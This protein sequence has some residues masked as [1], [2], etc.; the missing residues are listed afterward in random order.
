[1]VPSFWPAARYGGP[2][3]SVRRLCACLADLGVRVD[4]A[5]TN[6]DGPGDLDVAIDRWIPL[7]GFRVRYFARWPRFGYA[8]SAGLGAF[9][10]DSAG[11]YDLLHVTSTFSFPS[12]A[13]GWAARRAAKPY[14]VSPRGSLQNWSLAHKRWKKRPYWT[15]VER[16]HLEQ[17]ARVHVTSPAEGEQIHQILP[18]ARIV[19]VPNG[20][21]VPAVESVPRRPLRLVFLGRIHEV[22][23]FDVLVPALSLLA[24]THPDV[25]TVVAG[26]D[27]DGAWAKVEARLQAAEP[28]PAV[29][30]IG[31][32]QG[33]AKWQLLAS[34][35]AL[36]L[37]S[38]AENF[39]Q[40]VAEALAC[41]TP[42]VVS[43]HCPWRVLAERGAGAWVENTPAFVAKALREVLDA[44]PQAYAA[45]Q[46]AA[47]AIARELAWPSVAAAMLREYRTVVAERSSR[48]PG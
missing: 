17:A 36:V 13:S 25:E 11:Q 37:P 8:F 40:V 23:G 29:R 48:R 44:S 38:H 28:R 46:D 18:A 41:R 45:M 16:A 33:D 34:A 2:I 7:D 12:L 35:R 9:L 15:L 1:V 3:V 21:D 30:W 22:K 47:S 43:V 24:R 20:V 14:L 39:G 5:T 10:R 27:K 31:P 26:P 42:A 4:V 32:V 19:L 6:A